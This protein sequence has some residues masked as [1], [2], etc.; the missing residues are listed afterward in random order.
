MWVQV[1]ITQ[2]AVIISKTLEEYHSGLIIKYYAPR[3]SQRAV[4]D[5]V[6]KYCCPYSEENKG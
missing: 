6:S 4:H 1:L 5:E 2:K 3:H